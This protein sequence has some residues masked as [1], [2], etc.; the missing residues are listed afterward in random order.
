MNS[1]CMWR[2][3]EGSRNVHNTAI[4]RLLSPSYLCGS[5]AADVHGCPRGVAPFRHHTAHRDK[6][7]AAPGRRNDP[8]RFRFLVM[9][10]PP[11]A[12][13]GGPQS[14]KPGR[15]QPSVGAAGA[16]RAAGPGAGLFPAVAP[17]DRAAGRGHTRARGAV[18]VPA[19]SGRPLEGP[20][21]AAVGGGA[22]PGGGLRRPSRWPTTHCCWSL[23]GRRVPHQW[24]GS[25]SALSNASQP[26]VMPGTN[27][28]QPSA[29]S[30][31][32]PSGSV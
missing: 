31:S 6:P 32:L 14:V 20:G 19:L 29:S 3:R 21:S 28:W 16:S 27:A 26:V 25:L 1:R 2:D 15:A 22:R 9:R 24:L 4:R 30:T 12:V 23:T 17:G 8:N 11:R 13:A 5:V 10:G 7:V 18:G